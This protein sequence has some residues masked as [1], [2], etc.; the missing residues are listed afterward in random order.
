MG[1]EK[2]NLRLMFQWKVYLLV[3][4]PYASSHN[5]G[6]SLPILSAFNSRDS[7]RETE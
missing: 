6:S 3:Q 4:L 1:M 2:F 7:A 5:V